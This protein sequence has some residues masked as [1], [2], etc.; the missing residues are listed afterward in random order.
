MHY[1]MHPAN[2][3]AVGIIR[4]DVCVLANNHILDFGRRGLL[5]TLEVL[6]ASRPRVAGAGR[7]VGEAAAPAF[8]P[9]PRSGGRLVVFAFGTPSSRSSH[10]IAWV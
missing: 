3:P 1:R 2:V 9:I 10:L 6:A 5:Q 4:P 8:V 7:S